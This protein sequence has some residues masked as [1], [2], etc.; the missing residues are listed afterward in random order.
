MDKIIYQRARLSCDVHRA[1][2][3]FT[4]NDLVESWLAPSVDVEPRAGGKYELF[5]DLENREQDSTIGC[6]VTAIEED[7][8]LSF[9]W[10]GPRQYS[11]FMND[12][13]PLTHVVVFF[14]PQPERSVPSTEVHLVHSGWRASEEWEEARQWFDKAWRVA[15][16]DLEHQ[17]NGSEESE[18]D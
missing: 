10:K 15:F 7:R 14:V 5:W 18:G 13:D 3:M 2:E 1:F 8:F 16:E 9:E 12:A 17:I 11:R 4:V 6:R